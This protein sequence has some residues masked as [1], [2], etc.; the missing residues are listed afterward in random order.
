MLEAS[1]RPEGDAKPLDRAFTEE[2]FAERNLEAFLASSSQDG[3]P[4]AGAATYVRKPVATS[5]FTRN[6]PLVTFKKSSSCEKGVVYKSQPR[7]D[8][9][10]LTS[11]QSG[12][13]G[14]EVACGDTAR[15]SRG[16][17]PAKPAKKLGGDLLG[18]IFG[19]HVASKLL[20][21]EKTAIILDEIA[22]KLSIAVSKNSQRRGSPS[23]RPKRSP[24]ERKSAL[25]K[26][27]ERS[28]F[29]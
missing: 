26:F 15:G 23:P 14:E 7:T 27:C 3:A 9:S 13:E 2:Y 20:A 29:G 22:T 4:K 8:V 6:A 28:I 1:V 19:K 25:D 18:A 12:Q 11:P 16:C 24:F 21:F 17:P 5:P 10:S